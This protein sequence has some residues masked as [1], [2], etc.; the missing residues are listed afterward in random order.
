MIRRPP[1][2]TLFPYT[3]LF[4]SANANAARNPGR[5]ASTAAALMIG[6]TLVTVVAVLGAGLRGSVDRAVSDQVDAAYILS[7][8]DGLPFAAAEGDRLA[9]VEGVR[10][11][12]HV[13]DDTALVRGAEQ[14]VTGIDP[15][16]IGRFYRFDWTH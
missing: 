14:A 8:K 7:G 16:T 4:R 2:S 9:Q 1:R 3:T 5:T 15:A 10:A 13:R 6:L 12:S 11:A